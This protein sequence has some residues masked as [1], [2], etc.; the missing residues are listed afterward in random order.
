VDVEGAI[1][2]KPKPVGTAQARSGAGASL[3][4]AVI[5]STVSLV[6][7]LA[8]AGPAAAR[9]PVDPST[10]NPAPPDNFNATCERVGNGVICD[11][12]FSDPDLV[13]EPSGIV[14]GGTELLVSQSRS[15]VG[16]RYY[17]RNGDLTR[18][19]FREYLSGTFSNPETGRTAPWLQHDTVLHDLAVPGDISTGN[20]HV[21]GLL[22][23]AWLPGGG[24]AIVDSGISV[25]LTGTDEI[26]HMSA[27]HPFFDYF[28]GGDAMALAPLC[29]ALS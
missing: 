24:T 22:T 20:E 7:A 13:D 18:R 12:A 29:A 9:E 10:L 4:R 27:N 21:S 1:M 25:T 2:A 11:L 8:I 19:H 14:C 15:V 16:N 26:L 6:V 23:R 28:V 5:S 3:V 17:D